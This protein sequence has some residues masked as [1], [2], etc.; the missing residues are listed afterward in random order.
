M[1]TQETRDKEEGMLVQH[2]GTPPQNSVSEDNLSCSHSA[3]HN[4]DETDKRNDTNQ[5]MV[6]QNIKESQ[7]NSDESH[8]PST[9]NTTADRNSD[10]LESSNSTEQSSTD[11]VSS[12]ESIVESQNNI[13]KLQREPDSERN[14]INTRQ[15]QKGSEVSNL[16]DA[17]NI[18]FNQSM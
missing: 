17:P 3:S 13:L 2:P 4:T 7:L 8:K 11:R 14:Q 12:K 6:Q 9:E 1:I 18:V 16:T 15:Q 5:G 10:S